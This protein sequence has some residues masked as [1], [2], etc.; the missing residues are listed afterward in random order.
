[1]TANG[2]CSSLHFVVIEKNYTF[3]SEG[4]SFETVIC[5]LWHGDTFVTAVA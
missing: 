2:K 5:P 3:L 1:M 4:L